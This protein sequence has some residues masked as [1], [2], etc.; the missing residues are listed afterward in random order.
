MIIWPQCPPQVSKIPERS[1]DLSDLQINDNHIIK[2]IS[3]VQS[4]LV[5]MLTAARVLVYNVRP[6]ALVSSHER[7]VSSIE[8]FGENFSIK[9][10]IQFEKPIGGLVSQNDIDAL[11]WFQGKIVFFVQTKKNFLL[12]YQILKSS[13]PFNIFTDYGIPTINPT[14][15]KGRL[16]QDYYDNLDDEDILTVFEKGKS[17]KVIQNGFPAAKDK[18]IFKQILNTNQENMDELP[19]KKIELR[20]KIVLKFDFEILDV[21]GFKKYSTLGDG[22]VEEHLIVLF[23]HG[24]QLLSLIDFKLKKSTLIKIYHGKQISFCNGHI[25]VISEYPDT[26]IPIVNIIDINEQTVKSVAVPQQSQLIT[27]FEIDGLLTLIFP[28]KIIYFNLTVKQVEYEWQVP[29]KIKICKKVQNDLIL[30]I[31]DR[32]TLHLFTKYGNLLFSTE[33]DEDDK[34]GFPL[35]TYTDII[36][37]DMTLLSVSD[38]GE[39]Q[40]WPLYEL[41]N[42]SFSNFRTPKTHIINDNHNN[43]VLYSPSNDKPMNSDIFPT[44][45]LPTKTYNNY[46]SQICVNEHLK[47]MAVYIANKDLLLIQ[48]M[49]TNSWYKF[50]DLSIVDMQWLGNTYLVCNTITEDGINVI[51]C[52]RIPLQENEARAFSDYV[53]WQ[54]EVPESVS[55]FNIFV[56]IMFK[57]KMVKVRHKDDDKSTKRRKKFHKTG[58]IILV[59]N[60]GLTIFDAISSVD[61][62]GLNIIKNF[63]DVGKVHMVDLTFLREIKWVT[64]YRDG[65]FIYSESKIFK[66][67]K[68]ENEDAWNTIQLLDGIESIL[69]IIK[70]DIFLIQRRNIIT[71]RLDDLWDEKS[72]DLTIPIEEDLY[73]LAI[74]PESA[75]FHSLHCVF[76]KDFA[77]LVVKHEIYLDKLIISKLEEPGVNL[78]NI[79][80]FYY[81]LKHY[82]FALEKILSLKILNNEDL[83][84][85]LRLVKL[86][87]SPNKSST[88]EQYSDMLEI[89]SNCLRKI[90]TKYWTPLFTSLKMTPR[91]LLALCIQSNEAKV[92]GILLLVF[93]NYDVAEK[94][95]QVVRGM[96]QYQDTAIEQ[97]PENTVPDVLKDQEL[98]L[99]ILKILVTSAASTTDRNKAAENWDMCFQLIRLLKALDRENNTNLV[100]SAI[101]MF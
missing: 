77:K 86:C 13:T 16:D 21:L 60:T 62:S 10:S 20:L 15:T 75:T 66:I 51:V 64:N 59:T 34:H 92:L 101:D 37:L 80:E 12:T 32:N 57:Y 97:T 79:T 50:T 39:Y 96:G 6:F 40:Q 54:Y 74:S 33:Y 18:S 100:D 69:D 36:Y 28:N 31:S 94:D 89:V 43:I 22:K 41:K 29:I 67:Q 98:M 25:I 46:I 52:A 4:N 1:S 83:T 9:P 76:N 35:F 81:P 14:K 24:L 95:G 48:N 45:N 7:S 27:S 99:R 78:D 71:L 82:K 26:H 2:T 30:I 53:I 91:D 65:Y 87:H 90:E 93:L 19:I 5:V 58:E 44:I 88:N 17:S 72:A 63:H 55:I 8:E 38:S 73:P 42:G 61:I 68:N 56:N 84:Q 47:L 23:P 11:A 70:D 85:I 49:E 3:L